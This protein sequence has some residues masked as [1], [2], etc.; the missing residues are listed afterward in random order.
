MKAT[1]CHHLQ[2][3]TDKQ[4]NCPPTMQCVATWTRT[5]HK[6]SKVNDSRW[7]PPLSSDTT[8]PFLLC[9]YC[10]SLGVYVALFSP[11]QSWFRRFVHAWTKW[12]RNLGRPLTWVMYYG[13]D[14]TLINDGGV[15]KTPRRLL[16][17]AWEWHGKHRG[18]CLVVVFFFGS[19][20]WKL[21]HVTGLQI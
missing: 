8:S 19:R 9:S 12:V 13:S 11:W 4:M 7:F 20:G 10:T 21:G 5:R 17:P 6:I 15:G 18:D 1:Q 3:S 2:I 14:G 16:T